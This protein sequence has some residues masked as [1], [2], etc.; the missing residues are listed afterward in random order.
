MIDL[1][2]LLE[3]NGGM[4]GQIGLQYKKNLLGVVSRAR[5]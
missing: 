1:V 5:P 2:Y 3:L 4:I